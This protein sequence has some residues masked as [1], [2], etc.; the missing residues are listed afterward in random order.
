MHIYPE[1]YLSTTAAAVDC[2]LEAALQAVR[3]LRP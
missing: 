1:I 2:F 3:E